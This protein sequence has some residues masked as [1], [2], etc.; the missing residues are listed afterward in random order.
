MSPAADWLEQLE[1]RLEQQLEAFLR[2]NPG[3]EALLNEQARRDQQQRQSQILLQAEALRRELLQI[4]SEV[5]EWRGRGVRARRAGA[6]DLAARADQQ[7][8][9]QM[10][11][12]RLRW[13]ALEQLEKELTGEARTNRQGAK[14]KKRP[15]PEEDT[16]LKRNW[17]QFEIQQEI[18]ELKKKIRDLY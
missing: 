8:D 17:E 18:E 16:S 4:A 14:E 15:R 9:L 10:E 5:H 12:G 11:R 13:R 2:A 3:Q 6:A 1:A 7:V